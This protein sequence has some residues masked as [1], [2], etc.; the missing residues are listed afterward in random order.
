[1]NLLGW[2]IAPLLLINLVGAGLTY[3]LAW[4]PAQSAFDQSLADAA[5]ALIPRLRDVDGE[6]VIDLPQQAEQVLRLDHFDAIF[7][8]VRTVDG[9]TIAGD[10]DFPPLAAPDT[11]NDPVAYG[12]V[13]RAEP[14]RIISLKTTIGAIPVSIG[15]G[16]TLRKR[17]RINSEI[18]VAMILLEGLLT[19]ISI[20]IVWLGVTKGL[21]PLKKMQTDLHARVHDELAAVSA[22]GIPSELR[23]VVHAINSLLDK[24]QTSATAQQAFLANVA[25]QLRT[26]LAGLQ[27]QIEWLQQRHGGEHDT[28]HSLSM[29]RFSTERMI[30]QTNQLLSLARADTTRF[31]KDRL[32]TVSLDKLVEQSIQY[33]VEQA[34]KKKIDLGFDLQPVHVKGD[35]FLLRDMIDNLV[36][37]AI[38]YSPAHSSVTVR[39]LSDGD[40]VIFAVEDDGPGIADSAR[41]TIFN[42]F[43][44]LDDTVTGSGLGLAIVRDIVQAHGAQIMLAGGPDG[45]GTVFTVRF[46]A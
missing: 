2:L 7:F 6:V 9:R 10:N 4:A 1:M 30:R 25:H 32:D 11:A 29:M 43:V 16:E 42:R 19:A 33:F 27:M 13:M 34:D 38:R 5:W 14:V 37:N 40:H 31:E 24:V 3:W 21:F 35:K 8:V 12:G 18:L 44:R 20:A 23:P 17:T 45:V 28:T 39:C 41:D 36:D 26:P 15:V 46:P 22:E